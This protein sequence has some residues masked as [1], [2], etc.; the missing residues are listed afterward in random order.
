VR[1][2]GSPTPA[3]KAPTGHQD[4]PATPRL[5]QPRQPTTTHPSR[6]HPEPPPPATPRPPQPRRQLRA[7]TASFFERRRAAM[8]KAARTCSAT[9][10]RA[11]P[12]LRDERPGPPVAAAEPRS[13]TR[14]CSDGARMYGIRRARHRQNRHA[15]RLSST[16][17]FA[18]GLPS[19]TPSHRPA[20]TSQHRTA[21]TAAKTIRPD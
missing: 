11:G 9:A 1:R 2:A 19:P 8:M 4:H 5:P 3:A 7:G 18:G 15:H 16:V 13:P 6:H 14:R 21:R 10:H 17:D 20:I 12:S